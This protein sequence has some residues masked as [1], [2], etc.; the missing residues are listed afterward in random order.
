MGVDRQ[1]DAG[2]AD[3]RTYGHCFACWHDDGQAVD[4]V[5]IL[6]VLLRANQADRAEREGSYSTGAGVQ[7]E[8]LSDDFPYLA[9]TATIW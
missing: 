1:V 4:A 5:D 9:L 7:P 3:I 6:T 8:S 2:D